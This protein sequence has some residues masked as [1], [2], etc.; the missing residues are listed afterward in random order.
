MLSV[1]L[2]LNTR[3][4]GP[5]PQ[6]TSGGVSLPLVRGQSCSQGLWLIAYLSAPRPVRETVIYIQTCSLN[7]GGFASRKLSDSMVLCRYRG[8]DFVM[9]KRTA[10]GRCPLSISRDLGIQ[11]RRE[12]ASV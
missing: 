12:D 1:S 9:N 4:P 5:R 6:A 3:P 8:P 2:P 10:G 11:S 7:V